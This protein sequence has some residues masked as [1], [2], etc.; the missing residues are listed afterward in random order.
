MNRNKPRG[1]F[2]RIKKQADFG[3]YGTSHYKPVYLLTY[4]IIF[5]IFCA[6]ETYIITQSTIFNL[7]ASHYD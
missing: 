2:V 5:I 3:L 7:S 1:I 4:D 6:T